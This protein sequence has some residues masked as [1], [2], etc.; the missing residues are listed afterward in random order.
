MANTLVPTEQKTVTFYD[1]QITAVLDE[2]GNVYIPVRPICELLGV[3]WNGQR[4]RINRDPVLSEEVQGVDVTSTPGGKQTMLCLP[5]DYISGFLFGIN[6]TRVKPDLK[7]KIIRYQRECYKVLAEAFVD[8][9]LTANDGVDDLIATDPDNAAVQAYQMALAITKLARQ[10][11][12]IEVHL[13]NQAEALAEHE[14][15]LREIESDFGTRLEDIESKLS[16]DAH[17]SDAQAAQLSQAVKAVAMVLGQQ[18]KRNEFPGVYGELY[19][20]YDCSSYKLL[21]RK[22]FEDAMRWIN[23]WKASLETDTF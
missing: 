8:G 17:I 6:A 4:R 13:R 11:L 2:N 23:D 21:L 18:T 20:R 16:D 10:Q 12:A 9:R 19:R 7:E 22:D 5:L 15:R 1:D 14:A 3:D